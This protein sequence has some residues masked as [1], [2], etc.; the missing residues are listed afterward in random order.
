LERPGETGETDKIESFFREH[1][2]A[3]TRF[4]FVLLKRAPKSEWGQE[5]FFGIAAVL[6]MWLG[7]VTHPRDWRMVDASDGSQLPIPISE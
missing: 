7:E 6:W 3:L 4:V 1:Y 2:P 5:H